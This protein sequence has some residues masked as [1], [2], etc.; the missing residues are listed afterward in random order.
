MSEPTCVVVGGGGTYSGAQGFE[1]FEGI[2]AE[3][4]GARGLC[5][6]L[7]E[8]PPGGAARPHLHENHET[9]IYMLGGRAEMR[10]GEGLR[11]HLEV[12]AGQFLFIPAG[13]PHLPFNPSDSEPATALLARTDPNEQ[14]SVVLLDEQGRRISGSGA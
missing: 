12:H 3:T 6:H 1:Y 8:I 14:E 2:S 4:A 5:M 13:M 11:E 9:A 10:Y 7:L